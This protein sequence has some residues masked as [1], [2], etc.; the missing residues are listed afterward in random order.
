MFYLGLRWIDCIPMLKSSSSSVRVVVLLCP[1]IWFCK[2]PSFIAVI[3]LQGVESVFDIMDLEDEERN[4]LLRLDDSQ[5]QV[6]ILDRMAI[7]FLRVCFDSNILPQLIAFYCYRTLPDFVI[8]IPTLSCHLKF[9][10]RTT[11][12]RKLSVKKL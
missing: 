3:T 11:S 8:V 4:K 9:T 1:Y 12:Q 7:F 2:C 10:T 5:M 6:R